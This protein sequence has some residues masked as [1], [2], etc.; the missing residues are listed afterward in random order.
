MLFQFSIDKKL[1]YKLV[2]LFCFTFL[3]PVMPASASVAVSESSCL[4][5]KNFT[6]LQLE[7]FVNASGNQAQVKNLIG[8]V[9]PDDKDLISVGWGYMTNSRMG[10]AGSSAG[11]LN[12]AKFP[13]ASGADLFFTQLG[14]IA[15]VVQFISDLKTGSPAL[16]TN[17]AKG[18]TFW[19][20]GTFN[21][22]VALKTYAV[23]VS[24][25]DL[26]LNTWAK[27]LV[28]IKNDY[29]Y[30]VYEN[31][32]D[33]EYNLT[34]L[35]GQ[36][37]W[38]EKLKTSDFDEVLMEVWNSAWLYSY[39]QTKAKGTVGALPNDAEKLAIRNKYINENKDEF[40]ELQKYLKDQQNERQRKIVGEINYKY[41]LLLQDLNKQV[42]F[43]GTVNASNGGVGIPLEGAEVRIFN[44]N[45]V[46]T[47]TGGNWKIELKAC[48]L[49]DL[50][51]GAKGATIILGSALID[52][53]ASF[54]SGD[55]QIIE[56]SHSQK[57]DVISGKFLT[58][59]A[60]KTVPVTMQ[61]PFDFDLPVRQVSDI[62]I[63]STAGELFSGMS[64]DLTAELIYNDGT[65][66]LI[67]D[68]PELIW[69]MN[70]PGLLSIA[71]GMLSLTSPVSVAEWIELTAEITI[72]NNTYTSSQALKIELKPPQPELILEAVGSTQITKLEDLA[73]TAK[74][75]SSGSETNVAGALVSKQVHF[76]PNVRATLWDPSGSGTNV[77]DFGIDSLSGREFSVWVDYVHQGTKLTSNKVV[78][79]LDDKL[80]L[81]P[82][83]PDW[84]DMGAYKKSLEQAELFAHIQIYVVPEN[85]FETYQQ[86][87][88]RTFP[89]MTRSQMNNKVVKLV[90][91]GGSIVAKRSQV[92]VFILPGKKVPNV[93]TKSL[94]KAEEILDKADLK[95]DIKQFQVH[96]PKFKVGH[97]VSQIPVAGSPVSDGEV[98]KIFVNPVASMFEVPDLIGKTEAEALLEL[99]GTGLD[100]LIAEASMH[101]RNES[102][103][104]IVSQDPT[105]GSQIKQGNPI[106]AYVNP[107]LRASIGLTV[108]RVD[109]DGK[110]LQPPTPFLPGDYLKFTAD[111]QDKTPGNSYSYIW[112]INGTEVGSGEKYTHHFMQP[113]TPYVQLGL[114]SSDPR[115]DDWMIKNIHIEYPPDP[116]LRIG[117]EPSPP[118]SEGDVVTL[119]AIVSNLKDISSYRWYVNGVLLG[120][121]ATR[122]YELTKTGKYEIKLG[123]RVG[124]D[125]FDTHDVLNTLN[126]GDAPVQSLG[127][128]RNKFIGQ[129]APGSLAILSSYW[130]GGSGKWSDPARFPQSPV[131]SVDGYA[132]YTGEN[133]DQQNTGYLVYAPASQSILKYRVFQF[134]FA[135]WLGFLSHSGNLDLNQQTPMP[136]SIRWVEKKPWSGVV[137]WRTVEGSVCQARIRKFKAASSTG[138]GIT[139]K[140]FVKGGVENL[141]CEK[142]LQSSGGYDPATDPGLGSS[143]TPQNISSAIN[144]GTQLQSTIGANTNV[145]GGSGQSG[146][147]FS[148]VTVSQQEITVTFWDHGQEDGDIINIYLNG[149][150]LKSDVLLKSQ[151]QNFD[152]KLTSGKNNFEVEAVNEGDFSPNTASVT[153]SHVTKGKGT[154]IYERKSGQKATM[155]LTAP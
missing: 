103:G 27:G 125:N 19:A 72:G 37:N 8:S 87:W 18:S 61:P 111:I 132:L 13:G 10:F 34:T 80:T 41:G 21:F 52:L 81:V 147:N 36:Q 2:L 30:N 22:S 109:A 5:G 151:K 97:I 59:T 120:G 143:T 73:L 117:V 136:E 12:I 130:I 53:S 144:T 25:I 154:Q 67:T 4:P 108:T 66:E 47:D 20:I 145:P 58:G 110:A 83:A 112:F 96:L 116:E 114:K 146:Q 48:E 155:M 29:W 140:S 26:A 1:P 75:N 137:E 6:W 99:K 71:A 62:A 128:W 133:A 122:A 148:N 9:K 101:D 79:R 124:T 65:R 15:T 24:F 70:K 149:S 84:T 40:R 121:D 78:F 31:Y 94:D 68:S 152:L 38:E 88:D 14:G 142:G 32:I 7:E 95:V 17:A 28:T 139:Q 50:Y 106:S 45:P 16:Q 119:N 39:I 89:G 46:L 63:T 11:L 49:Y 107:P 35:Q 135:N 44:D 127:K 57:F 90:P 91:G 60:G 54:K 134:S 92:Q 102:V 126:V 77:I 64:L 129:G 93:V 141:K 69:H 113:G 43:K 23:G 153:I 118:Y 76:S 123:V 98:I 131:G 85:K 104:V 74:L 33:E 105:A 51:K 3:Y 150:M 55:G 82:E 86:V 138:T 42:V 115:E 56:Q 100:L